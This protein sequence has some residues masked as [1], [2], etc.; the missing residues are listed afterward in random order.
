MSNQDDKVNF[1]KGR[2]IPRKAIPA[3]RRL[4]LILCVGLVAA[5][6]Y[7][8]YLQTD[9]QRNEILQDLPLLGDMLAVPVEESS[10]KLPPDTVDVLPEP[11]AVADRAPSK[12]VL[13]ERLNEVLPVARADVEREASQPAWEALTRALE[14][15]EADFRPPAVLEARF[16][17]GMAARDS[18]RAEQGEEILEDLALNHGDDRA[19]W[20]LALHYFGVERYKRCRYFLDRLP[21]HPKA[22][23]LKK[24]IAVEQ[25]IVSRLRLLESDRCRVRYARF[26]HFQAARRASE[27]CENAFRLVRDQFDIPLPQTKVTLVLVEDEHIESLIG[28]PDWLAGRYSYKVYIREESLSPVEELEKI[29]RHEVTHAILGMAQINMPSWLNEGL[30]EF[31]EY[32]GLKPGSV[33]RFEVDVGTGRKKA[34]RLSRFPSSFIHLK[35][36]QATVNHVYLQAHSMVL[37]LLKRYG[38]DTVRKALLA[39]KKS[40]DPGKDLWATLGTGGKAFYKGWLR[41]LTRRWR[42]RKKPVEAPEE[43]PGLYL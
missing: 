28:G 31:I 36:D 24:R 10:L 32:E 30:A 12:R 4:L 40:P 35:G 5:S 16:W 7:I 3:A 15:F 33:K 14:P 21:E 37:H 38:A 20:N 29:S 25:P 9:Q 22:N 39:L 42:E 2:L 18:G 26:V 23:K 1:R 43:Y 6:G 8:L 34:R 13:L 11:L 27:Q 19:A 17:L 41:T